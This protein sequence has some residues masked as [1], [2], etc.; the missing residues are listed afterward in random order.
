MHGIVMTSGQLWSDNRR[1]SLRVFRD[2]GVGKMKYRSD[3]IFIQYFFRKCSHTW[4]PSR[5]PTLRWRPHLTWQFPTSFAGCCGIPG[6]NTCVNESI[7]LI[8]L[9]DI[10]PG[11]WLLRV[12]QK[13]VRRAHQSAHASGR[14][15]DARISVL[16]TFTR[17]R[18]SYGA[19]RL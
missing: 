16:E 6:M 10:S 13:H 18:G 9:F 11:K 14:S 7:N 4:R 15:H 12:S 17:I 1:F 19:C 5:A 2:F 8:D 3:T